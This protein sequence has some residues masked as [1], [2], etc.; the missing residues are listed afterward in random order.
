MCVYASFLIA[1][2]CLLPQTRGSPTAGGCASPRVSEFP[3]SCAACFPHQSSCILCPRTGSSL[4][5]VEECSAEKTKYFLYMSEQRAVSTQQSIQEEEDTH[6]F[7]HIIA[8]LTSPAFAVW[9][10]GCGHY[11][12]VTILPSKQGMLF[13]GKGNCKRKCLISAVW[14]QVISVVWVSIYTA[15]QQ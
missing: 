11:K 2:L 13:G 1:G 9:V 5:L 4:S 6:R 14:K 8:T 15:F 12:K 10:N 3:G 7:A